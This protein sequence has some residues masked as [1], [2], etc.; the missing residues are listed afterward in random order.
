MKT[1]ESIDD[2]RGSTDLSPVDT[3]AVIQ[4]AASTPENKRRRLV[5]GAVA[6]A[7]LVL[8]LRSGAVAAAASCTGTK[9]LPTLDANGEFTA[10]GAQV[11]DACV[12]N[13]ERNSCP[14]S[15][16]SSGTN[17]GIAVIEGTVDPAKLKCHNLTGNVAILSNP[18]V[19]SLIPG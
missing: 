2:S 10:S 6:F 12:T 18:A 1:N 16:I 11:G 19:N 13:Y 15:K 7:P 3:G 9:Q 5:R 14:G 17:P 4:G 8:T